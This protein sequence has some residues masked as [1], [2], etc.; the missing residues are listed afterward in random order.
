MTHVVAMGGGGF[1]MQDQPSALDAFVLS[2]VAQPSPVVCFVPTAS[3]DADS[4]IARFHAAFGQLDCEP[5]T[6]SLFSRDDR[7]LPERLESVDVV[8]VGGGSTANLLALWRLH[9]LDRTLRARAAAGPLVLCGPSAGGLCWFE[10]GIT[11]SY[12][13]LCPLSDGLAWVSGSFCPHYDGEPG[14]RPAYRAAIAEGAIDGGFAADDGA[15]LHFVDGVLQRAV[16]ERPSATTYR[17]QR[18]ADEAEETPMPADQL[19]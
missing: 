8:Y 2:L 3:G 12:G 9:G 16:T 10:G 11:D 5:I 7:S 1:S 6:L 13:P 18:R 4:Y 19:Q 17:V 15:A 14:R